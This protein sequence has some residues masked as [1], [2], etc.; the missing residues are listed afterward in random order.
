MVSH[1]LE[2]HTDEK[3]LALQQEIKHSPGKQLG[4]AEL[5]KKLCVSERT[6]IRR[7]H[8]HIGLSPSGYVRLVR[9]EYVKHCLI[10]TNLSLTQISDYVGYRDPQALNKQFKYQYGKT[11]SAF[12]RQNT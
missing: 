7:F 12:R 6:L 5:A 1:A 3:L 2:H 11:M 4:V 8:K 9:L 10:T